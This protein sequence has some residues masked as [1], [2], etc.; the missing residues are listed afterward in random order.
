MGL[1]VDSSENPMEVS[2]RKGTYCGQVINTEDQ[3]ND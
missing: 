3:N 1:I 2:D